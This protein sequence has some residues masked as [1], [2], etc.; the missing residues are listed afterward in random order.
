[1]DAAHAVCPQCLA[2]NRLTRGA[3]AAQCGKCKAPLAPGAPVALTDQALQ[4]M[5]QR[6]QLPLLVDFWAPWC[7]PCKAMA[8]AFAQAAA[9]LARLEWPVIACK[10]DTQANQA[11]GQIHQ[12]RSIPTVALFRHGRELARQAGVMSADR[13]VAWTRQHLGI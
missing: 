7:G 8:P 10:V 3:S 9:Q 1:M 11:S 12:I 13:I 2:V 6:S 5:V 4:K